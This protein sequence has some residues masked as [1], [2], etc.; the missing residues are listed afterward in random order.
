MTCASGVPF[1]RKN[2]M[3][4]AGGTSIGGEEE[5]GRE[6]KRGGREGKMT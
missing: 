4:T 2:D 6:R 5:A 3:L 1:E